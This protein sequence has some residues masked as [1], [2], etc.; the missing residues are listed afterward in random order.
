MRRLRVFVAVASLAFTV[1]PR[2]TFATTLL[3]VSGP[4]FASTGLGEAPKQQA[5]AVSFTTANALTGIDL[6]VLGGGTA[7]LIITAYLTDAIGPGTTVA[8]VKA[9]NTFTGALGDGVS[10]KAFS[11]L[12]LAPGT[13]YFLLVAQGQPNLTGW[14]LTHTPTVTAAPGLS[15][16]TSYFFFDTSDAGVFA[17]ASA[18][19][20]TSAQSPDNPTLLFSLDT[21]VRVP[22]PASLLLLGSG[23]VGLAGV[24]CRKRRSQ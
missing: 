7:P 4:I 21:S 9:S 17:P 18:N 16:G 23:V 12:S 15:Y 3:S 22:E 5:A 19:F 2:V 10:E 11:G 14:D 6:T 8:D 20:F 13:Y 1:F 24:A